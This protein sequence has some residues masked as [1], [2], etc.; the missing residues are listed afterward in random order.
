MTKPVALLGGGGHGRVVLDVLRAM[1]QKVHGVVDPQETTQLT[2]KVRW[3]GADLGCIQPGA[4][5]LVLGVGSVGVGTRNARPRLFA[6]GKA[7]G[8]HFV[9]LRHPSAIVAPDVE[10]AEGAQIMAGAVIQP[11]S[12]IGRNVIINTSASIDHDCR[13]ADHVHVAPGVVLSGGVVI[14]EGA[15]LGT[16]AIVIQGITI[17]AGAMIG[18]GAVVTQSVPAGTR[19]KSAR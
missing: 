14:E 13:I 3:L 8:F 4:C 17:G 11:G 5:D 19:L 6:D 12:V 1:G 2:G 9:V 18:A 7:A 10:I 15:H 16:G